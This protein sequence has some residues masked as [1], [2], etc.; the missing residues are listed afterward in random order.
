LISFN[1]KL[2]VLKQLETDC[3]SLCLFLLEEEKAA[4]LAAQ[5]TL[6]DLFDDSIFWKNDDSGKQSLMVRRATYYCL[7]QAA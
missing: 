7:E 5:H 4:I 6:I 2:T 1:D 3:Y